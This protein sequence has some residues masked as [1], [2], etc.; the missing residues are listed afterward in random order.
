MKMELWI[1]SQYKEMLFKV[2][3]NL[4]IR[5][6][7]TVENGM[8]FI[9]C[10]NHK[11]A[12]YKTRERALEVLDEIQDLLKPRC[13]VDT[14]SIKPDGNFY[15]ENG[16]VFQKYNVNARIEELSTFVYQMP[17]E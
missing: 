1:R 11:I 13:I 2:N 3:N 7:N 10:D 15:E 6:N 9:E 8:Y 17:E 14:S 4:I 12:M 5:H 16:I